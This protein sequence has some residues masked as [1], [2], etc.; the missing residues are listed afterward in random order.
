V[1][2]IFV[3]YKNVVYVFFLIKIVLIS[4]KKA[5]KTKQF[6][7]ENWYK[8]TISASAL[9]FSIGFFINSLQPAYATPK[10]SNIKSL[11]D[12]RS[13]IVASNGYVYLVTYNPY[14]SPTTTH[15]FEFS[16]KTKL[17]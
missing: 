1:F 3:L 14:I 10:E 15:S 9:I 8:V 11:Y 16:H 13:T 7:K 17:P 4:I 12:E 2:V 6:L 5:M